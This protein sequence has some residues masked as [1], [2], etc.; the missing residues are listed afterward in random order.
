MP[1]MKFNECESLVMRDNKLFLRDDIHP[2]LA[3]EMEVAIVK[4]K[5][6]EGLRQELVNL[7]QL[8]FG[9]EKEMQEMLDYEQLLAYFRCRDSLRLLIPALF[10]LEKALYE[11]KLLV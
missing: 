4:A 7:G 2:G 8:L 5:G 1:E 9:K 10:T 11:H 6:M 3:E